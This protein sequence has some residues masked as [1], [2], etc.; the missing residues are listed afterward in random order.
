MRWV[1]LATFGS[2]LEAE[3]TAETLRGMGLEAQVRSNDIVGIVGPGF[4]GTTT[5]GVDVLVLDI[6][7]ERARA[8]LDDMK[9]DVDDE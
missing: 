9:G 1:K 3:F 7:A 4:Q 2:G 5:G 8:I 6:E